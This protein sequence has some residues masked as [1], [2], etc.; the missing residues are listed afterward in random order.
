LQTLQA[1]NAQD[2]ALALMFKTHPAPAE[3]LGALDK[4]QPTLDAYAS[5]AQLAE[6]FLSQLKRP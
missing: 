1:M 2:S 3:R 5:Q 6:R 4:M